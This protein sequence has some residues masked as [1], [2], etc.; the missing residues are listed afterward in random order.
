MMAEESQEIKALKLEI[1]AAN[2]NKM[3]A[4]QCAE[5]QFRKQM[6]MVSTNLQITFSKGKRC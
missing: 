4:A 6:N 5:K 1:D 2:L 3:R